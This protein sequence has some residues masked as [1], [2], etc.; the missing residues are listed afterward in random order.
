[1][2]TPLSCWVISDGRRGIENQA[3]GLAESMS[4]IRDIKFTKKI[5]EN[6]GIFAALPAWTQFKIRKDPSGLIGQE[7]APQIAIGCGRQAIAPLLALKTK[8]KSNIFTVYVQNPRLS[9]SYFDIV[10]A[11]EHD[12]LTDPNVLNIIGSPNRVTP[13]ALLDDAHVF[14]PRQGKSI[15]WLVG[16]HSKNYRLSQAV[17]KQHLELL[18]QLILQNWHIM[19]TTSRRT[20]GRIARD[21]VTLA[22]ES[23]YV[24]YYDGQG[25]NPYFAYLHHARSIFVTEDSTN[26]LVEACATGKPVFR[27]PMSGN[28]GKFQSLYDSLEKRC[29]V[30]YFQSDIVPKSYLPLNETQRAAE[31]T[32]DSYDNHLRGLAKA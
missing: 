30:T 8:L 2:N 27:L 7:K 24:S 26:M 6:G 22:A 17:H 1:M 9:P 31:F 15:A 21:Y 13:Q 4:R 11:P 19:V 25:S 14:I 32:W 5:I 29:G 18:H 12:R 16:G 10:I 28:P 23:Q 20:P 3:L